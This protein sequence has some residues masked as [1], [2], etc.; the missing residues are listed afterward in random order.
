[1]DGSRNKKMQKKHIPIATSLAEKV[2][3]FDPFVVWYGLKFILF[4]DID[5]AYISYMWVF[6]RVFGLS[7]KNRVSFRS[8]FNFNTLFEGLECTCAKYL[9]SVNCQN[10]CE[11]RIQS[12]FKW[13]LFEYRTKPSLVPDGFPLAPVNWRKSRERAL[14]DK[15]GKMPCARVEKNFL[16]HISLIKP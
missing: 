15:G 3:I 9:E 5:C 11:T 13:H 8:L 14:A 7:L 10:L 16:Q 2:F 1:M 12:L 4:S 6:V